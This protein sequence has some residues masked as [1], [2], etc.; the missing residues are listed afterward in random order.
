MTENETKEMIK[1]VQA[2]PTDKQ[3]DIF[4]YISYLEWKAKEERYNKYNNFK[5]VSRR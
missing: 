1:R 5:V 3:A 2:L 4:N